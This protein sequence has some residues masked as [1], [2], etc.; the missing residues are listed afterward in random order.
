VGTPHCVTAT[1]TDAFNNA[2][3]GV[4]VRFSVSGTTATSGSAP[5]GAGGTA[6]FCYTSAAAGNDT[7][8]AFAD[9][10]NDTALSAGEPT[11]AAAKTWFIPV[12][13]DPNQCKNGGWQTFGI[14]QN[15]G[16]CVSFVN[17]KGKT[18]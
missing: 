17:G 6:S 1:V 9:S 10:N 2:T 12:P 15:Q 8:A 18:K 16:Q 11:G 3:P 7:I 5:T 14:F 4:T 13:T